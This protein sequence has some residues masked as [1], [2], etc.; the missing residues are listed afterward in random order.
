MELINGQSHLP[1]YTQQVNKQGLRN[2]IAYASQTAWLQQ[3]SIRENILFGEKM[4]EERYEMTLEACAL[5][6]DLEMLEDGD[7]TEIG[8]KGVSMIIDGYRV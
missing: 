8:A 6:P 1:K 4:D 2:S 5:G 3:K 7:Q